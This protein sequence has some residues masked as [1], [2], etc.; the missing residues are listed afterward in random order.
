MAAEAISCEKMTSNLKVRCNGEVILAE[1]D[2]PLL[3]IEESEEALKIFLPSKEEDLYACLRTEL[4]FRL[5]N[6]LKTDHQTESKAF[7]QL[8]R[9]INDESMPLQTIM[10]EEGIPAVAWLEKSPLNFGS[11]GTLRDAMQ[12]KVY[13]R[14]LERIIRQA[15]DSS[16]DAFSLS[17]LSDA[18]ED[19]DAGIRRMLGLEGVGVRSLT[20]EEKAKIDAAGELY[21]SEGHPGDR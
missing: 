1:S 16:Q 6:F 9:I 11:R 17:G 18:L 13:R 7:Q 20:F 19:D 14:L 15:R 12:G 4:P 3:K 5:K 2:R 21:V 8:Y 10:V